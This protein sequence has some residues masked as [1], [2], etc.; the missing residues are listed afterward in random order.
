MRCAARPSTGD[1]PM[2]TVR[3]R[4]TSTA[5]SA[6]TRSVYER[7]TFK[8]YHY[9]ESPQPVRPN[10]YQQLTI[11]TQSPYQ[12]PTTGAYGGQAVGATGPEAAPVGTSPYAVRQ[13]VVAEPQPPSP[14]AGSPILLAQVPSERS[15]LRSANASAERRTATTVWPQWPTQTM[16]APQQYAAP[17]PGYAPAPPSGPPIQYGPAPVLAPDPNITPVTPLPTNPQ[18]SPYQPLDPFSPMF[19]DPAVDLD[20]VLSEA[21]TGR[22]DAGRG[23]ELR[24][25]PGGANPAR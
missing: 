5:P 6:G 7:Q 12:L 4:R 15:A 24:R 13:A 10:P 19:V 22:L 20:V 8:P 25:R 18:L 1:A 9:A 2:P 17:P 14:T 21:Q 16:P 3:D 11:R 23:R